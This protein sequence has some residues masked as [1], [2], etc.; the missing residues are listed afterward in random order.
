[1]RVTEFP[2]LPFEER[3]FRVAAAGLLITQKTGRRATARC[4]KRRRRA[5]KAIA[6]GEAAPMS[7]EL[8]QAT[9]DAAIAWIRRHCAVCRRCPGVGFMRHDPACGD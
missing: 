7:L 4:R 9:A 3:V 5:I 2:R 6:N 8:E 1:M